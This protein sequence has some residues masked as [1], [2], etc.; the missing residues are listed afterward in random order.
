[1]LELFIWTISISRFAV[2]SGLRVTTPRSPSREVHVKRI[3]HVLHLAAGVAAA[4]GLCGKRSSSSHWSGKR[5]LQISRIPCWTR[6]TRR[7]G[8]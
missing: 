2:A 4:P 3:L 5:S 7:R 6:R 1:M 8:H